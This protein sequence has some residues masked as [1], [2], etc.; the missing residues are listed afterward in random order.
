MEERGGREKD[1]TST[2][3]PTSPPPSL[4]PESNLIGLAMICDSTQSAV[5]AE[6]SKQSLVGK[7]P[8]SPSIR[9][10][11]NSRPGE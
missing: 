3:N 4:L 1:E 6:G 11:N 8:L 2:I 7:G 5:T 10:R 9:V